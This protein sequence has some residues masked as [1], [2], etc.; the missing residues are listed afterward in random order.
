M[1]EHIAFF[2]AGLMGAPLIGHYAKAGY[3]VHA[4]NRTKAKLE[5]IKKEHPS[6]I[7][8]DS[9]KSAIKNATKIVF[10]LLFDFESVKTSLTD[11]KEELKG[12]LIFQMCTISVQ[13]N[14]DLNK[15]IIENGGEYIESPLIGTNTIAA[16]GK[17]KIL[18]G[19]TPQQYQSILPY[20]APIGSAHYIGEV[21]KA[22]AIKLC[23]NS[24]VISLTTNFANT[25][26]LAESF[27]FNPKNFFDIL[28]GTAIHFPYMDVKFPRFENHKYEDPNFTV[29]GAIKDIQLVEKE[30]I[31][32]GVESRIFHDIGEILE[33]TN[34]TIPGAENLDFS[35][36][37]EVMSKTKK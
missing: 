20:I 37:F 7:I 18:I 31:N 24:L 35:I 30:A 25:L 21:G 26:A 15:F 13:E 11:A 3:I 14:L 19:A 2:G 33:Y 12:K 16:A 17:L 5:P 9:P 6:I 22:S 10:V 4:Y 23:F 29:P 36:L 28:K 32:K 1:G 34:K 8:E 27:G